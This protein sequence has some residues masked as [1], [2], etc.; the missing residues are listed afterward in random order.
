[1]RFQDRH[2][3][4][5]VVVYEG[6]HRQLTAMLHDRQ[7]KVGA[8]AHVLLPEP[9]LARD[10]H[11]TAK[12]AAT[13]VPMLLEELQALGAR[14]RRIEA[15]LAG[16]ASPDIIWEGHRAGREIGYCHIEKLHNLE[17]LPADG[18]MVS[19]FPVKVHEGSAGWTRAVAILDD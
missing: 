1:M 19:C 7:A 13:A 14:A 16:G 9:A 8:L 17:A 6:Q 2:P 3:G 11:N 4:V 12:F 15:R 18:F 10:R 5:D